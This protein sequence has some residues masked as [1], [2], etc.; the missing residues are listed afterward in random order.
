MVRCAAGTRGWFRWLP[1]AL[2]AFVLLAGSAGC[3]SLQARKARTERLEAELDALRYALP[4]EQVWSE[5]RRV[6]VDAGFT[7]A[8]EDAAAV[9][10]GAVPGLQRMLSPAKATRP[11]STSPEGQVT[12]LALDTGWRGS[13]EERERL[14]LEAFSE[15]EGVRVVFWRFVEDST[16]WDDRELA[17]ELELAR[18]LDSAAAERI[19]ASARSG[20]IR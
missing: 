19:E 3:A 6:L 5:A 13:D 20:Q 10:R 15:S 17:L 18:R 2:S 16:D 4:L 11:I 1:A 12:G 8:S 14:R 7:L 9:G